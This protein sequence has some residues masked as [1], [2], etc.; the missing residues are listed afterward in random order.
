[1]ETID[2]VASACAKI[3]HDE[4]IMRR[5]LELNLEKASRQDW[6]SQKIG[7]IMVDWV[8]LSKLIASAILGGLVTFSI[9]WWRTKQEREDSKRTEVQAL[10]M[11]QHEA[12]HRVVMEFV[13]DVQMRYLYS[14]LDIRL[15]ATG[16]PREGSLETL[17][18]DLQQQSNESIGRKA[19]FSVT[20]LPQDAKF[21]CLL[22]E[23]S[24]IEQEIAEE[25]A[26]L[27]QQ[28]D[29][30]PRPPLLDVEEVQEME[31]QQQEAY[32][33]KVGEF[34]TAFEGAQRKAIAAYSSAVVKIAE[35]ARQIDQ[36]F[37]ELK[38]QVI[39]QGGK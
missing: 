33:R 26:E 7:D 29:L 38:A 31:D 8:E 37:E 13:Q 32:L 30:L 1:M 4:K 11:R 18:K 16:V 2:A 12:Q 6:S 25:L 20:S 17:L 23:L 9:S 5:L 3:L 28:L 21:G 22:D 10:R 34:L 19:A 14:G 15:G 24:Q 36:R 39:E 35:P 27:Q